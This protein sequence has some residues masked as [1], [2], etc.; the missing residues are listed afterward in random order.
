MNRRVSQTILGLLVAVAFLVAILYRLNWAETQRV[1]S[2]M[3]VLLLIPMFA[4]LGVHYILKGLRWRVLLAGRGLVTRALACRLTLI[5]FF[6][7]NIIPAR[8]GELVRPYLLSANQPQ[9]SF[10]FA[11]ATVFGDKIYD[12]LLVVLMMLFSILFVDAPTY[13]VAGI[14][15]LTGV[16]LAFFV[17]AF[18]GARWRQRELQRQSDTSWLRK[19]SALAGRFEDR[20][21]HAILAFLDGLSVVVESLPRAMMALFYTTLSFVL[22]AFVICLS[23]RS[24][25]IEISIPAAM[26]VIGITGIGFMIPAAP[27]NA[28]SFHFFAATALE[29]VADV[30]W[31]EAVSFAI[32]AHLTQVSLVSMMGATALVGLDLS[33]FGGV[34]GLMRRAEKQKDEQ[35]ETR[36][37]ER[38]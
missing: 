23:A 16:A 36:E 25:H 22:L 19:L 38:P 28:G 13:V 12:L 3:D 20:V 18:V 6:M 26:F 31:D 8:L 9:M 10:P 37:G 14:A 21:Y 30:S 1:L 5:G 15:L 17:L 34:R 29:L 24:L 7:N 4:L 35:P 33:R 2:G 32:V 11:V 27:T